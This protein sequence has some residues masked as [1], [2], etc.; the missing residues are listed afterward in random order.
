MGSITIHKMDDDLARAL[1]ERS[2][3][4]GVSMNRLVKRLLRSALG[5]EK[6]PETDHRGDFLDLFGT[7]TDRETADFH[8]RIEDLERIEPTDWEG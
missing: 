4:E 7:W 5:L 3:R 6:E 2:R 8:R 1:E